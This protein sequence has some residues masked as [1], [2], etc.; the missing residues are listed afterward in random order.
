MI[1]HE[2]GRQDRIEPTSPSAELVEPHE[3]AG[4]PP[5]LGGGESNGQPHSSSVSFTHSGMHG[6]QAYN[7]HLNG[8]QAIP[9]PVT[10]SDADYKASQE[11]RFVPP[12]NADQWAAASKLLD[13]Y[14]II[15]L[16]AAQGTGRRT[17]A[18]RLLRTVTNPPSAIFDLDPEWSKPSVHPL[19]QEA[20]TGYILDLSDLPEQPGERLG[21]D[22]VGHGA[23]LRKNNS[24]LVILATP[25]D[26]YGHWADPTLPFTVRLESPDAKEL[27]TAELRAHHRD[28]RVIWLEGKEFADIWTANP[29][30]RAAWRLADRLI[31]ASGPE[32]IQAIVN[33]L[34]DWHTEIE[35]LLLSKDRV[36]G[37]DSQLLS[38]RV[39]VWA[40]AL[41][42][43][44]QRRSVIKAADDLLTRLG[45]E[46]KP[47][48]VLTD[49][50]TSS[51][52]DGAKITRNGDRAFHDKTME[53][54]PAAILRHLWDEFP[55]Q[56]DL[57]RTWAIGIAADRTI[58][59][60]DARLVTSALLKLAVH[61]HDRAILDGLASDLQ[62][63]RRVLAVE[64]LTEAAGDAEFGRYVRDR[65]RQWMDAKAPSDNKV[66]LVI[67]ICA[68]T[69]GIN[70]PVLALTRLGKAAGHKDFGSA[71]VVHAFQELALRR[72]EHV[73]KAVG[74]WLSDAESGQA[75]E[76]VR[77]QTLRAFLALVASDA[78]T[79]LV[80]NDVP[81]PEARLRLVRA[82]QK[83]LS[84]DAAVKAV[85][86]QLTRWQERFQDDPERRELVLDLLADIFTP[87]SRR[88]GLDGL[89]VTEES[90][91]DPFWR[92]VLERAAYRYR[93]SEEASTP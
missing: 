68:G 79:D 48:N 37:S 44:G 63:P 86:R 34:G 75:D 14:G 3:P 13:E 61:R 4:S 89:M 91:I 22:L 85:D 40:G 60:E 36:R 41:L 92:E 18:M 17:A 45:L 65:L 66:D 82:W 72:P 39:M 64:A 53:G 38:T 43:G 8:D 42:H 71:A 28:D 27:V 23:E 74:Q 20:A 11:G 10:E 84:T 62:G 69:W 52:L 80:L 55:T 70:Q 16:C 15:V 59:E 5:P 73:R 88:S 57:L 31:R 77:R 56:R 35:N 90:A 78:G 81:T 51:R 32:Q 67:E 76:A 87:P 50:T 19:P 47:A 2:Q 49:A 25:A 24:F 9:I 54:L 58:P 12:R 33:E 30:A 21:T 1:D 46:R 7:L 26:W 93:T 29:S 83:L 6:I